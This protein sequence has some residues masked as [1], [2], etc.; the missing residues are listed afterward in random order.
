MFTSPT[1]LRILVQA[2]LEEL[3][4]VRHGTQTR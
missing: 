3:R 4:R 1:L 2:R